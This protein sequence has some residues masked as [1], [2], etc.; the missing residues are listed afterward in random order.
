MSTPL[1]LTSFDPEA[2]VSIHDR[3]TDPYLPQFDDEM[4]S[5]IRPVYWSVSF[6]R[7]R[8]EFVARARNWIAIILAKLAGRIAP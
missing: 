6:A 7:T 4:S 8:Y 3:P 2:G 5:G 1:A